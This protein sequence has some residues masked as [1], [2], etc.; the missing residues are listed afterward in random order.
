MRAT[1]SLRL[2]Y[3]IE[4]GTPPK[5]SKPTLCPS[6]KASVLSEGYACTRQA[7]LC[8]RSIAKKWIFRSCPPLPADHRQRFAEVDLRVPRIVSQRHEHL[9]LP[10]AALVHV[11]LYNGDPT[12]IS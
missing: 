8:G 12:G 6:Q 10:L 3:R 9:A 1:A 2:S 11:V 5:N 7:S 4:H